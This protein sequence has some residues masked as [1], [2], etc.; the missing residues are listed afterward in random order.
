M[1]AGNESGGE[2][3]IHAM[4]Q[5]F[6]KEDS[7][8]VLSIDVSNAFN[9]VNHKLFL[10]NV[11]VIRNSSL[12]WKLLLVTIETLCNRRSE[13]KSC[14]GTT[15]RDP[16]TMM[17]YTIAIMPL[18]FMLV[19]QT[20]QLHGKRLKTVVYDDDFTGASSITNLL[21]FWN[22]FATLGALLGTTLNQL[23]IG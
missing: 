13:L 4:S 12:C 5:I 11:S 3:A 18:L 9:A 19:D 14:E 10:R 23:H 2:A 1:C 8:A 15:Q 7:E 21:H 16:A 17:V 22:T 6:N 20:E